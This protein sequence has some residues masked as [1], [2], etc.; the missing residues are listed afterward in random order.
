MIVTRMRQSAFKA[1][2]RELESGAAAVEE[3]AAVLEMREA[4]AQKIDL[5]CEDAFSFAG[6]RC[7]RIVRALPAR[8]TLRSCARAAQGKAPRTRRSPMS[9]SRR[10]EVCPRADGGRRRVARWSW[11]ARGKGDIAYLCRP[12]PV[13]KAIVTVK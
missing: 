9:S 10:H 4:L 2:P 13:M 3:T 6:S 5:A 8:R 1:R 7:D 12:H 11:T